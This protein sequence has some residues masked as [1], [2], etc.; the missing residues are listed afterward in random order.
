MLEILQYLKKILTNEVF[1][2]YLGI[3]IE[4]IF[5]FF[6]VKEFRISNEHYKEL[7]EER[8]KKMIKEMQYRVFEVVILHIEN[9][10]KKQILDNNK[11]VQV[12]SFIDNIK[13]EKKFLKYLY[14]QSKIKE[15]FAKKTV[16]YD[17]ISL[18]KQFFEQKK[19][20][21]ID[22]TNIDTIIL[23]I[24]KANELQ[25]KNMLYRPEGIIDLKK[26]FKNNKELKKSYNNMV[27]SLYKFYYDNKKTN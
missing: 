20:T 16:N 14:E 24:K 21:Q 6:V 22:K 1:Y 7:E 17:V 18:F 27:N 13:N 15:E 9:D 26:C 10:I 25:Y 3:A 5:L 2:S 4:T 23:E 12:D 19:I 8:I 11:I